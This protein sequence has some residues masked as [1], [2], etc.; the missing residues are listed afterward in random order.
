MR[1]GIID[2][3]SNFPLMEGCRRVGNRL[4]HGTPEAQNRG[5][6]VWINVDINSM[7]NSVKGQVFPIEVVDVHVEEAH[8]LNLNHIVEQ[9]DVLPS[10]I[11]RDV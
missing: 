11:K 7:H 8:Y 10:A 2:E 6:E 5:N 9:C 3:C 4:N 1:M